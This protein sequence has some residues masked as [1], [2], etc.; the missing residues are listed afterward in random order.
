[1]AMEC[2]GACE[3]MVKRGSNGDGQDIRGGSVGVDEDEN[4][5]TDG[6]GTSPETDWKTFGL[7]IG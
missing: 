5:E 2:E 7:D 1:M 4:E 3:G 6:N